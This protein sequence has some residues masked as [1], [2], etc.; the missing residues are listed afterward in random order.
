MPRPP[1]LLHVGFYR[2][3]RIFLRVFVAGYAAYRNIGKRSL[4][5]ILSKGKIGHQQVVRYIL[6][7]VQNLLC[8]PERKSRDTR[9]NRCRAGRVTVLGFLFLPPGQFVLTISHDDYRFLA[10]GCSEGLRSP[11]SV[12]SLVD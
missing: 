6:A 12:A 1:L 4:E 8:D 3:L 5:I 11:V 2:L 7:T 9:R 10:S